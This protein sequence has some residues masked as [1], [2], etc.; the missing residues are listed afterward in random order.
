MEAPLRRRGES[1][2]HP[3]E[4]AVLNPPCLLPSNARRTPYKNARREREIQT[5]DMCA[6]LSRPL[7]HSQLGHFPSLPPSLPYMHAYI[8]QNPT[9]TLPTDTDCH[10]PLYVSISIIR[11][12]SSWRFLQLLPSLILTLRT[13]VQDLLNVLLARHY[14]RNNCSLSHLSEISSVTPDTCNYYDLCNDLGYHFSGIMYRLRSNI[15]KA[16]FMQSTNISCP[17]LNVAAWLYTFSLLE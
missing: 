7:T 1:R 9:H 8:Q 13:G 10:T 15:L 14:R 11:R 12:C 3:M 5:T 17:S 2:T 16:M 6:A 4:W